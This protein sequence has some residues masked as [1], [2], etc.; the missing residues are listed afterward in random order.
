MNPTSNP[1]RRRM[2]ATARL[3]APVL[4]ISLALLGAGAGTSAAAVGAAAQRGSVVLDGSPGIPV[5]NPNTNTVYVPIQ[6]KASFCTTPAAGRVLDVINAARCNANVTA[7]CRVLAKVTVGKSPLAAVLDERTDTIYVINGSGSVSVVNGNRCNA[8]VTSGCTRAVATIKTGGFLVAGAFDPRTHTLYAASPGGEVVVINV[9]NCNSIT[10]TGCRQRVRKVKDSRDPQAIDVD[11]A[12]DTVYAADGGPTGNGDTVTVINGATCN[13]SDGRG[14]SRTLRT[15]TVGVNPGWVTVDQ[16]TNTV[17]VANFNDGTVSVV[18]GA[19]CNAQVSSG[20]RRTVPA[21]TTGAGAGSVAIDSA[22]H[23]AFVSNASDDTISEIDTRHCKGSSTAGCPKLAPA[24][25]AGSNGPRGYAGFPTQF[26]LIARTGTAYMVTVGASDVLAIADV[27]HCDAVNHSGCRVN[28]ASVP[29]HE[30][31]ATI[32]PATDT[33]YASNASLPQI[34]VLNGA[35]CNAHDH[36]GCAPVAEIPIADADASLSAI[37]DAYDTLYAADGMAGTISL[38][39]TATCNA[40]DTSGCSARPPTIPLAMNH[41]APVLNPTTQT[42]YTVVG[43]TG[44]QV[45][46]L[47]AATCN[48]QTTGGCGQTPALV[49]VGS[50]TGQLAV[51][52]A[53]DTIYAP[54]GGQSYSGDTVDV[55]NGATCNGTTHSGCGKPAATITVGLGPAGAAVDDLTHTLYVANNA[56]GDFPGTVSVIN[57]AT[58]DG[59]DPAGCAGHMPTIVVG[60]SSQLAAVDTSTNRIYVTNYSSASVSVIDGSTCNATA[61]SGCAQEAAQQAVGSQPL[62][63]AINDNTNTVY[64]L[65]QLG[66]GAMSIFAGAP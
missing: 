28:A 23:T 62:G 29:D 12:T 58:C 50:F 24:Q 59:A 38:I 6:C 32:D 42:L 3:L 65:T 61:T 39:D 13:G 21:V 57:T 17:Y 49:T 10:T 7:G 55:I 34:D 15:I 8:N 56:D 19:R 4:T 66:A 33:I 26:A 9:A 43:K 25:H 37:D 14:C 60:R 47:N 54:S 46:V 63:L 53:T 27:R 41:G 22:V 20:C 2:R 30:A 35:T 36:S 48:A 51:S 11:L 31:F 64:A 5:A 1:T 45:A 40:G 52:A 44:N 18:N 16:A